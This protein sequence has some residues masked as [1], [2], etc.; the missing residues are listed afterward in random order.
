LKFTYG[1]E[2]PRWLAAQ[3]IHAIARVL[4]LGSTAGQSMS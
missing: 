4:W 1:R 3:G 2:P